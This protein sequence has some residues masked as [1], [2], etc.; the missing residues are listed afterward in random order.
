METC[1]SLAALH[2]YLS[3]DGYVIKNPPT[4][5][6]KYYLIALRNTEEKLLL[7]FQENSKKFSWRFHIFQKIKIAVTKAP[8]SSTSSSLKDS[9]R[10]IQENGPSLK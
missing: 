3:G 4:Q 6:Q 5:K 10:S 7:D 2:G 8:T 1:T 9:A